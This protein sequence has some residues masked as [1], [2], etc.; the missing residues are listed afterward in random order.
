MSISG[1][2][3][4]YYQNNVTTM[5][6]TKNVNSTEEFAL[7]KTSGTQELSE[8]EEME[9]FKKE[10]YEDLSKITN[11]RT[12]SNAAVNISEEAFKAMKDDP[13]YREKVLSLIQRDWGDSYAPRNCSVLITVG[14]TLNEYRAD[15]WPVGYDSEFDMRS[16][17]SFYKR[18]SEKKDRQKELL[19]EYLENRAQAK[20]QQLEMLN[21]KIAKMELERSRQTTRNQRSLFQFAHVTIT[22]HM[23][24]AKYGTKITNGPRVQMQTAGRKKKE[25]W[26]EVSKEQLAEVKLPASFDKLKEQNSYFYHGEN[27]SDYELVQTAVA[28]GKMELPTDEKKCIP[29]RVA[30]D[31]FKVLVRDQ[32]AP[33]NSWSNTLYSEDGKYTFTKTESGRWQMHLIDDAAIG[34]SLEDIANWMMSGTPNRNIETRYL[35]YLHTVDPDLYNVAM[36][37]GSEVR[38]YGFME[39]LHQQGVLSDSQNQ[40]DMSLLGMLFGKDADSM[41][42]ILNGCKESGN[43]LELLDLYSPDGAKSL[44]KLREQQYK[45]GG[46]V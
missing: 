6:S 21:K 31:A 11:H 40:Y 19:E 9:L 35:N 32:A 46:I 26:I 24:N 15:S 16:Q 23:V 18:T 45:H 14:A 36:R 29:D 1:I 8:A 3:E 27:I 37:I 10:F 4:K 5:K 34:A 30:M 20:K 22:E 42:M 38:S 41:R 43:F 13:Q 25:D 28:L 33:K 39:D 7:E 17:N 2:G 12:V 44:D